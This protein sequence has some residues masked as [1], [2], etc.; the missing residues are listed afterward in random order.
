MVSIFVGVGVVFYFLMLRRPPSSTRTAPLCPYPTLF[1]SNLASSVH[2]RRHHRARH[3]RLGRP[4][5]GAGRGRRRRRRQRDDHRYRHP[6][7]RPHRRRFGGADRRH[8]G[9]YVRYETRRVGKK[10][11]SP[12]NT[13]AAP[14][15]EKKKNKTQNKHTNK[16]KN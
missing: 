14:H 15:H 7:P 16:R 3:H 8:F 9:G 11:R 10:G 12:C 2:P 6:P 4:R 13:R 1:R 5:R